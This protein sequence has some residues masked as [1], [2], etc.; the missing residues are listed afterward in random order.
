MVIGRLAAASPPRLN[1]IVSQ[2][3]HLWQF[4]M[5]GFT[6]KILDPA[7]LGCVR[8]DASQGR[9]EMIEVR[10]TLVFGKPSYVSCVDLL[11][12]DRDLECAEYVVE[13]NIGYFTSGRLA[14]HRDEFASRNIFH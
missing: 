3:F 4:S 10:E 11:G 14:I 13:E 12:D 6:A 5:G 9:Y 8:G 7:S 2:R 1:S